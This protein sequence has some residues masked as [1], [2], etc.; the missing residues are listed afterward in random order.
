[1]VSRE[2][3]FIRV[4][5]LFVPE[6]KCKQSKIFGE[7][8]QYYNNNGIFIVKNNLS[9]WH[10]ANSQYLMS[11]FSAINILQVGAT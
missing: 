6:Q 2:N 9:T 8:I 11:S 5:Q 4:W 7:L 1:M 3:G 10:I